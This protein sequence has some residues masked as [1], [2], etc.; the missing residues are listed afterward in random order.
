MPTHDWGRYIV[1]G[2][3]ARYGCEKMQNSLGKLTSTPLVDRGQIG[4]RSGVR[5]G[6]RAH[7][8]RF[9]SAVLIS[10]IVVP[11]IVVLGFYA[12]IPARSAGPA[13][14]SLGGAGNFVILAETTITTTGTTAIVGNVGISPNPASSI[15]GF[16]LVLDGSGTFSTSSLVTG[17][18]VYASDYT[19][20]TPATLTT[21]ISDMGTAYTDAAG[22]AADV[23]ELGSGDITSL[24]LIPQVYKWSSAVTVAAAGVTIQAPQA[25]SGSSR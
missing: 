6:K 14:V 10:I 5:L 11:M 8:A 7:R 24:T 3:A 4:E 13:T 20:P 15:V 17:G 22:R 9:W 1:A 23:T 18:N 2:I 25:M 12:T 16:G 21:A 19:P